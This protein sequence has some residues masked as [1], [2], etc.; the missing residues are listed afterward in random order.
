MLSA[1]VV[2]TKIQNEKWDGRDYY[3]QARLDADPDEVAQS[4]DK[5]RKDRQKV[6][7][8]EESKKKRDDTMKD[9][10]ELQN[11]LSKDKDNPEKIKQYNEKVASLKALQT[12]SDTFKSFTEGKPEKGMGAIFN[13]MGDMMKNAPSQ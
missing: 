8:L 1:G 12:M 13:M 11:D 2:K 3:L 9:I 10:N 4:I 5:L 6:K 7:E